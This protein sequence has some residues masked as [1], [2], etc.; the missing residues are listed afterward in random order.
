MS[1]TLTRIDQILLLFFPR[2]SFPTI[3]V[4]TNMFHSSFAS[5][6]SLPLLFFF[7]CLVRN[8]ALHSGKNKEK[9]KEIQ[10]NGCTLRISDDILIINILSRVIREH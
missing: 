10:V 6:H 9:G 2:L 4:I 3:T 8:E 7:S 5:R 1:T